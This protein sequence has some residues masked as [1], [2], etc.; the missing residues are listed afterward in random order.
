[1]FLV[2]I[3]QNQNLVNVVFGR[4]LMCAYFKFL[5]LSSSYG[6]K[7]TPKFF[8]N[9]ATNRVAY[10]ETSKVLAKQRALLFHG[11]GNEQI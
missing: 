2:Q 1:M 11:V 7:T 5:P 9:I 8:E 6:S 10:L 3:H 4:P